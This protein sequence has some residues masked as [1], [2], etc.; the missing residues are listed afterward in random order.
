MLVVCGRIATEALLLPLSPPAELGAGR[1]SGRSGGTRRRRGGLATLAWGTFALLLRWATMPLRAALLLPLRSALLPA[2]AGLQ[3]VR[4]ARRT[5]LAALA[6][7]FAAAALG[8]TELLLLLAARAAPSLEDAAG[9]A[10]ARLACVAA[11]GGLL[12]ANSM[13]RLAWGLNQL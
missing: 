4:W 12:A 5:G 9:F 11:A 6:L 8:T 2:T 13:L 1:S 10:L 3:A 7:L